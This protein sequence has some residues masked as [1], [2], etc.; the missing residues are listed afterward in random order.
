M[1]FV[2]T[3]GVYN[4]TYKAENGGGD[5]SEEKEYEEIMHII[6]AGLTGDQKTDIKYLHSKMEEFKDHK[7]GKEIVRACG[8]LMA[9]LLPEEALEELNKVMNNNDLGI[10]AT[11]EEVQFNQYKKNFDKA[12]SLIEPLIKKI[13]EIG[14]FKDDAVSEYHSFD[15]FFEEILYKYYNEPKKDVRHAQMPLATVYTQYGSLLI[16]VGR[17]EDARNALQEALH[18]NPASAEIIFEYSETY[19]HTGELDLYFKFARDA[20][21]YCYTPETLA[22]AYRNLGWYFIEKELY[23][24][25][26]VAYFLSVQYADDPHVQSELYYI[27]QATGKEFEQPDLESVKACAKKYGFPVGP[28][29]DVLSVAYSL[30]KQAFDDNQK[31]AA[32]FFLSIFY[33]LMQDEDVKKMLDSLGE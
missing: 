16:D 14:F 30:G 20:F 22:R 29:H 3:F 13:E 23:E 19:K 31:D 33:G 10:D 27:S 24:D 11:L 17:W 15:N 26:L 5:M 21:K 12:I 1:S 9:K 6:T 18:W 28:H 2:G 32:K 4:K 25:A 8:R 7:Y